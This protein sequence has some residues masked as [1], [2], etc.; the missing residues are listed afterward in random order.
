MSIPTTWEEA[1]ADARG[2]EGASLKVNGKSGAVTLDD[3]VIDDGL[4]AA[5][6][7]P[8]AVH[9]YIRFNGDGSVTK[10]VVR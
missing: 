3:V 4:K 1:A 5:F 2:C 9:G 6:I 10:Q 7:M 8:T